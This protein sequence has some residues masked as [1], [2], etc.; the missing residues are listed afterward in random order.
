M[1]MLQ[2]EG[3]S[4]WVYKSLRDHVDVSTG[5]SPNI[6]GQLQQ[7][8]RV[9][10]ISCLYREVRLRKLLATFNARSIPFILLKGAYL[11]HVV[12]KD[13]A[14]RPMADVDLLVREE[15]FGQAGRELE[16]L[17]YKLVF[18]L[19]P[20]ENSLLRLP[21]EYGLSDRFPESI[22]LHRRIQSM[23]YYIFPADI[24][25]EEAVEKELYGSRVFYLSTELNFIHLALHN[26]DHGGSL[27]DWVDLVTVVRTMNLDWDRLLL[28]ARSLGTVRPLFWVFREL[29]RNWETQPPKSV[30]ESLDS[31]VPSWLEDRVIRHRFR[32]LWRLAARIRRLDGWRARLRYCAAKLLPPHDETGRRRISHYASYL[33]SKISLFRQLWRRS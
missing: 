32:Y 22:D 31:Y 1:K 8:Y 5:M 23:D 15:H 7:D 27:R 11:G 28:L 19:N 20:G 16:L 18:E 3:L 4:P 29:G 17:G 10:A 14:L 9:S 25:W 12:Y 33:K 30:S 13:P 21:E 2:S 24:L 26:F 6:L